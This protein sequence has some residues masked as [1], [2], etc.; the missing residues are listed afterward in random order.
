MTIQ[1]TWRRFKCSGWQLE[2]L[3]W[4]FEKPEGHSKVQDDHSKNQMTIPKTK[5]PFQKPNDR[6]KNQM[7]IRKTKWPFQKPNDNS[8]IQM[9]IQK[10][11]W[12]ESHKDVI[13]FL[14]MTSLNVL[15][16]MESPLLRDF[17]EDDSKN[18]NLNCNGIYAVDWGNLHL[19][20][21]Q[22]WSAIWLKPSSILPFFP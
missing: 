18:R 11:K 1:K 7:M 4:P 9:T 8:K 19:G 22:I 12:P 10:S 2:G 21:S 3:K 6:S 13:P 5:W 20:F 14:G 16:P 15:T 17:T